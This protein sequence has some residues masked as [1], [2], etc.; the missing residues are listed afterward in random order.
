MGPQMAIKAAI[1][2]LISTQEVSKS[3]PVEAWKIQQGKAHATLF[4]LPVL[5]VKQLLLDREL[6]VSSDPL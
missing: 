6:K 4:M 5:F 2:M 3:Q 1:Q